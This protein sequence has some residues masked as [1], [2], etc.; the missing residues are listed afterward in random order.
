[1]Q[2]KSNKIFFL[3]LISLHISTNF[4]DEQDNVHYKAQETLTFFATCLQYSSFLEQVIIGSAAIAM[5]L[6]R[7]FKQVLHI[8]DLHVH[9]F[10]HAHVHLYKVV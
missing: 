9:V 5:P 6:Y 1:M 8:P 4:F 3:N 2:T 10:I 7:Y